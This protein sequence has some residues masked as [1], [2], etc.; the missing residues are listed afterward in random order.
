MHIIYIHKYIHTSGTGM[1]A[2][3]TEPSIDYSNRSQTLT[4]ELMNAMGNQNCEPDDSDEDDD[5]EDD[6]DPYSRT[7]T[8]AFTY[9][10]VHKYTYINIGRHIHTHTC[11]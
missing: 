8:Y 6:E 2:P 4:Q 7:Y 11:S 3:S 5:E 10:L 9:I 1:Y